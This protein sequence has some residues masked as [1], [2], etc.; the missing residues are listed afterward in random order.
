MTVLGIDTTGQPVSAAIMKDGVISGSMY[1][2]IGKKHAETLMPL[3]NE[4]LKLA[5]IDITEIEAVAVSKGPGSFTGIRIGAAC[6]EGLARGLEIPVY[7]VNALDALL[8]NITSQGVKCSLMDARRSEAYVKAVMNNKVIIDAQAMPIENVLEIL[9]PY[10]RVIF[11]GDGAIAYSGIISEKIHESLIVRG[12]GCFQN[13]ASVCECFKRGIAEIAA[14]GVV[15]PEYLRLS[16]AERL[17]L[18][19][20]EALNA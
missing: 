15:I 12:Q 18:Q 13:A 8:E 2:N 11:N 19:K 5:E 9:S 1:L 20:T 17:K 16:Q 14:D 10:K 6:A 4:L 7:C 3:I